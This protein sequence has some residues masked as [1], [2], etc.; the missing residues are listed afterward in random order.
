MHHPRFKIS[1]SPGGQFTF[2]LTAENGAIILASQRYS[3]RSA[4]ASGIE[5]VRANAAIDAHYERLLSRAREPYFVLK[6]AN[7]EVIGTSEMYS[8]P[9]ARDAGI[10]SVKKNAVE[11]EVEG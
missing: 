3:S 2:N 7:G 9:G 6:A 10:E 4:A 8:S 1:N 11:A 5:S